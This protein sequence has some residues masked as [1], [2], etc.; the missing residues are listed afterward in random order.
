MLII[1][2]LYTYTITSDG[3]DGTKNKE[4]AYYMLDTM[5]GCLSISFVFLNFIIII[6][7]Y[8][9]SKK[10]DLEA[11]EKMEAEKRE[12]VKTFIATQEVHH[13]RGQTAS[14]SDLHFLSYFRKKLELSTSKQL[15]KI[16]F[17]VCNR[18]MVNNM[19]YKLNKSPNFVFFY[20]TDE[21]TEM[22]T[23]NLLTP[24]LG[25]LSSAFPIT[26][27]IADKFIFITRSSKNIPPLSSS[28]NSNNEKKSLLSLRAISKRH[29][30]TL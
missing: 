3:L 9:Q 23:S 5:F 14:F 18:Q 17:I 6:R 4:S 29:Q 11:N 7:D 27:K 12:A 8:L 13:Y 19:L 24:S 16:S 21:S 10:E 25:E 26:D 15:A 30:A 22:I 2:F 20:S 28:I 1:S